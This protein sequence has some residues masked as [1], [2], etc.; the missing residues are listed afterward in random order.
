MQFATEAIVFEQGIRTRT[1]VLDTS[2]K[3]QTSVWGLW[4]AEAGDPQ[5]RKQILLS[6]V[7]PKRAHACFRLIVQLQNRVGALSTAA[8]VLAEL[9]INILVSS[10]SIYLATTRK[11]RSSRRSTMRDAFSTWFLIGEIAAVIRDKGFTPVFCRPDDDPPPAVR[12][13]KDHLQARVREADSLIQILPLLDDEAGVQAAVKR[14]AWLVREFEAAVKAR[15][16]VV[17][18]FHVVRHR[19]SLSHW[20]KAFR[21]KAGTLLILR[22]P[23]SSTSWEASC[24]W[25]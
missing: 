15:K 4:S 22:S 9:G 10:C 6:L 23:T 14:M 18:L 11:M 24:E 17:Q 20:R 25:R 8:A 21:V 5:V 3:R 12:H 16:P 19:S 7:H 1:A 2:C 13:L